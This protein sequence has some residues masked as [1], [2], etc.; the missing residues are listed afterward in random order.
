MNI[1]NIVIF[2]HGQLI[3]DNEYEPELFHLDNTN[4]FTW[5]PPLAGCWYPPEYINPLI[6]ELMARN[7]NID[8]FKNFYDNI[9]EAERAVRGVT[10]C[11][12]EWNGYFANL[13]GYDASKGCG[14]QK[15]VIQ[16]KL[17]LFG[18][19]D[20]ENEEDGSDEYGVWDIK[21]GE[22]LIDSLEIEDYNETGLYKFSEILFNIRAVFGEDVQ[23]NVLDGT[24]SVIYDNETFERKYDKELQQRVQQDI[25]VASDVFGKGKK[26]KRKTKITKKKRSKARLS[27]KGKTI[28]NKLYKYYKKNSVKNTRKKRG[29]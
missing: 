2:G 13:H 27:K 3:M 6:N 8:S 20:P 4:V 28:K 11:S 26:S 25:M 24:C 14:I 10:V 29:G 1:V 22:N 7:D 18:P 16:D 12:E 21:T 23:I 9:Q 5:A 19:E 17:F 15:N